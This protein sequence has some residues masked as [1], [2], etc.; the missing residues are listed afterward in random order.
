MR[1]NIQPHD[2]NDIAGQGAKVSS[3]EINENRDLLGALD[4]L[5]RIPLRL[6]LRGLQTVEEEEHG[7]LDSLGRRPGTRLVLRARPGE[8]RRQRQL[9]GVSERERRR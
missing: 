9:L 3:V 1:R 8:G 5:E 7:P 4:L 6:G 2:I